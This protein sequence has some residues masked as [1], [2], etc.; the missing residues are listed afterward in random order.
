MQAIMYTANPNRLNWAVTGTERIL[1]N[2][3]N[4]LSTE[5]YEIAYDRTLGIDKSFIDKPLQE[6]VSMATAQIYDVISSR[7]PRAS[8]ESV[9]FVGLDEEG[10]MNFKV[11]LNIE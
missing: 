10:N 9:D 8:V 1:Q 2:V 6:A 7:E 4:L 5:K 11:V 3:M